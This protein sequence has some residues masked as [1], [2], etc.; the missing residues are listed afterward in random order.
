MQALFLCLAFCSRLSLVPVLPWLARRSAS[1]LVR[2]AHPADC[3]CPLGQ[4]V[5]GIRGTSDRQLELAF[6]AAGFI[7]ADLAVVALIVAVVIA[8]LAVLAADSVG[9]AQAA[10]HVAAVHAA[11]YLLFDNG[12]AALAAGNQIAA[13]ILLLTDHHQRTGLF[14]GLAA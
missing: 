8:R 12:C 2:M 10:F 7:E 6:D 11:T 13:T 4:A 1:I 14:R 3:G 9:C 5:V